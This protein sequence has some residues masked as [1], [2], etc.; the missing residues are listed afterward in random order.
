MIDSEGELIDTKYDDQDVLWGWT[1]ATTYIDGINRKL[2]PDNNG[3]VG[4]QDP[5][6]FKALTEFRADL[7]TQLEQVSGM[8][9]V[10]NPAVITYHKGKPEEVT[11][12]VNAI[13][14]T[15]L[16]E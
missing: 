14:C 9:V 16:T 13:W 5:T 2:N 12:T 15:A 10:I 1:Q 11:K 8:T 3:Y 7:I 6:L 4:D